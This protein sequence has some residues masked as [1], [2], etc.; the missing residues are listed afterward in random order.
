[1]KVEEMKK[2]TIGDYPTPLQKMEKLSQKHHAS[3]YI[4]RDDIMGPA[5]SGNKTRK[6][7][8]I[9]KDALEKGYNAILTTGGPGTSHARTTISAAC[10][11]GMKPILVRNKP[12]PE[13]LSGNLAIDAMMGCD[14]VNVVGDLEEGIQKTIAKYENDGYKVYNLPAKSSTEIGAAGYIMCI[15]EIMDQCK[16][17][18]IHPEFLVCGTGSLGTYA[19]LLCGVEYFHA[20]FKIIGIPATNFTESVKEDYVGF[21]NELAEFYQMNFTMTKYYLNMVGG[22][23]DHPYYAEDVKTMDMDVFRVMMELA[24]EEGI[25]LDPEYTGRAFRGF[26]DLVDSRK[27][28]GD[29]IFL[30]TGGG[31]ASW[32]PEQTD[33]VQEILKNNCSI[34][35]I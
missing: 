9:M 21:I 34:T 1:M 31:Q 12:M 35:E 8:Y 17:M 11:F 14:I 3:L 19:G 22:P 4:K 18:D 29:C 5:L 6:L 32:T 23:L 15:K 33:A 28:K 30:H 13:Y 7:E 10:Q 26:L 24:R 2:I 20:P 25:I 16:E 27:I